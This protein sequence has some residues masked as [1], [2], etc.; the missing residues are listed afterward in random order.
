V[1]EKERRAPNRTRASGQERSCCPSTVRG[2][3]VVPPYSL[4]AS[5]AQTWQLCACGGTLGCE[6][7]RARG[8]LEVFRDDVSEAE[9]A[10]RLNNR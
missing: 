1:R 7:F 8:P 4:R 6:R 3:I 10:C 9:E 2:F 5:Q